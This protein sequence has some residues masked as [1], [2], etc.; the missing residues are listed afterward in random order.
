MM[1]IISTDVLEG[2]EKNRC[3]NQPQKYRWLDKNFA[4]AMKRQKRGWKTI[5]FS[6]CSESFSQF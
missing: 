6:F 1:T 2:S 4:R 3:E 5:S